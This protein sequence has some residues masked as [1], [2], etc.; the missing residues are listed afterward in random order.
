MKCN[1]YL[2][3]PTYTS[4]MISLQCWYVQHYEVPYYAR[5]SDRDFRNPYLFIIYNTLQY[6]FNSIFSTVKTISRVD[7]ASYL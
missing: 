3:A 6:P 1:N 4:G 7:N 2:L 5:V